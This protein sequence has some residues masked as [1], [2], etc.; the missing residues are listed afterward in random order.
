MAIILSEQEIIELADA[1]KIGYLFK[2]TVSEFSGNL[3]SKCPIQSCLHCN[4]NKDFSGTTKSKK[5]AQKST[6]KSVQ[7]YVSQLN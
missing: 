7:M 4:I 2:N 3:L 6:C 1:Q 5:I